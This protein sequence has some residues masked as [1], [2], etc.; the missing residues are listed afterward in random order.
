[1]HQNTHL[2][3]LTQLTSNFSKTIWAQLLLMHHKLNRIICNNNPSRARVPLKKINHLKTETALKQTL[4]SK[5]NN[6]EKTKKKNRRTKSQSSWITWLLCI[7]IQCKCFMAAKEVIPYHLACHLEVNRE[8]HIHHSIHSQE[9]LFME[10]SPARCILLLVIPQGKEPLN[11][12]LLD[13]P[14]GAVHK[15][16]RAIKT[17]LFCQLHQIIWR[18][19]NCLARNPC[20]PHLQE[21]LQKVADQIKDKE[22]DLIRIRPLRT[23]FCRLL[24]NVLRILA[25]S[26]TK[27]V[28]L[29]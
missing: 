28:R 11:S 9:C 16:S 25:L 8:C 17:N 4:N 14:I 24:Q 6:Q 26:L 5:R 18:T 2:L 12:R 3:A 13:I 15:C 20:S 27:M 1:M 29:A 19:S 10:L 22:I 21:T 23:A 7:L